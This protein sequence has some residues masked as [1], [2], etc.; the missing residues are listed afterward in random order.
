[1]KSLF[2][3]PQHLFAA[4]I[5]GFDMEYSVHLATNKGEVFKS[6][7]N[8]DCYKRVTS[9]V[10]DVHVSD[11]SFS[12]GFPITIT[13]ENGVKHQVTFGRLCFLTWKSMDPILLQM[14]DGKVSFILE[15][16]YNILQ[17]KISDKYLAGLDELPNLD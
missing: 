7:H 9:K 15:D 12:G 17:K 13:L 1:M 5:L 11:M 3:T 10:E 6:V 4:A 16:Q 14:K 8:I 2:E